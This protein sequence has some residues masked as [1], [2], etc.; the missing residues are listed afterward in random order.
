MSLEPAIQKMKGKFVAKMETFRIEKGKSLLVAGLSEHYAFNNS[1][2]IPAQ[3]LRFQP[4]LSR[5]AGQVAGITYGVSCNRDGRGN[6]D[7]LCGVEVRDVGLL[8]PDLD[9]IHIPAHRYA[10]F[11][12]LGHI[13]KIRSTWDTI[14]GR[15]L[16]NSG[17]EPADAPNFERYG[18]EFDSRTG[19]GGLEIWVSVKD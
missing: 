11:S 8:P 15:S 6:F 19:L 9:R 7:Y 4:H 12:H 14:Y 2:G 1:T 17:C 16:P 13:S 3:W 10:V 18:E 5:I